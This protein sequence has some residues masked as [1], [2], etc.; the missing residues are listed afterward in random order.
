MWLRENESGSKVIFIGEIDSL[1]KVGINIL[2]P[3]K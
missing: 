3:Q 2:K 1:M